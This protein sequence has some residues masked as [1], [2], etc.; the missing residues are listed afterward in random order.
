MPL[1]PLLLTDQQAHQ[2]H[3]FYTKKIL[4][5]SVGPVGEKTANVDKLVDNTKCYPAA[6]PH[7]PNGGL[8]GPKGSPTS[9]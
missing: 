4:I 1:P 8:A 2:N 9:P 6:C 5:V 7:G 3:I